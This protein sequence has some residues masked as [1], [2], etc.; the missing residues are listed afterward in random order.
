[1]V[2]LLT[3]FHYNATGRILATVATA[4]RAQGYVCTLY[5]KYNSYIGLTGSLR[6]LGSLGKGGNVI[7]VLRSGPVYF[8]GKS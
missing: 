8:I 4:R 7:R 1:M 6:S 5:V 2:V 3:I